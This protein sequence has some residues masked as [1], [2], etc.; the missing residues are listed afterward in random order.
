MDKSSADI[1]A[2]HDEAV[3][4]FHDIIEKLHKRVTHILT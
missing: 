1:Q 3:E 4:D 2:R